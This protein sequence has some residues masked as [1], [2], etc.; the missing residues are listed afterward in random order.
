MKTNIPKETIITKAGFKDYDTAKKVIRIQVIREFK[1]DEKQKAEEEAA[2][3]G[4]SISKK[5][6]P[7]LQ[8]IIIFQEKLTTLRFTTTPVLLFSRK[9]FLL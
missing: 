7:N 9:N 8:V 4:D 3:K 6:R 2:N 1:E 5:K